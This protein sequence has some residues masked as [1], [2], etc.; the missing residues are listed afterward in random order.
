MQ[1]DE[2]NSEIIWLA[3]C[4]IVVILLYAAT[5]SSSITLVDAGL[6]HMVCADNGIA[7]PPGYPL[8]TLLCHPFMSLPFMGT[9]PG[10]L[11]STVFALATLVML[12]IVARQLAF[13][14]AHI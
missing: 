9:I 8:A 11:F 7:H 13:T 2:R 14:I 4:L 10:N 3:G 6:F 12:Y 1:P 5:M